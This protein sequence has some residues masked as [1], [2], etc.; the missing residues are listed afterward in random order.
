MKEKIYLIEF[1]GRQH[2]EII[3]YSHNDNLNLENF[4]KLKINDKIKK[5]WCIKNK[6]PLLAI[7]Y[8]DYSKIEELIYQHLN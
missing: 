5:K 6:I 1:Q 4:K 3:K 2:Y 7:C 8:K